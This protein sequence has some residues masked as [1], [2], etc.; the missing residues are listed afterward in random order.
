MKVL[1]LVFV[2]VSAFLWAK[3]E[4]QIEGG[5]GWAI[6]LPTWRIENHPIL[7]LVYGGRPL[8]GYHVWCLLFFL[9]L[10]HM[11]F[12]WTG[13]WSA[14]AELN[15]IGAY[16]LFW[17]LE[18]FLWFIFNPHYGW[19]KLTKEHAW[20]HKRW[21]AGVPIDYWSFGTLGLLLYWIP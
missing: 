16:L 20:W 13:T 10:F 2:A 21:F 5:R 11:P 14:S 12:F 3:V 17:V 15:L 8:T 6:D 9:F 18:D 19:R 4:I 7:D 1:F